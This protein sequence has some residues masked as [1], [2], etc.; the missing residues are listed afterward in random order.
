MRALSVNLLLREFGKRLEIPLRR[1]SLH[2]R[3]CG[4]RCF[5]WPLNSSCAYLGWCRSTRCQCPFA[6]P[7]KASS[8]HASHGRNDM[9]MAAPDFH[10]TG[11]VQRNLTGQLKDSFDPCAAPVSTL[12]RLE[13]IT[14]MLRLPMCHSRC[15]Q[16]TIHAGSVH[17]AKRDQSECLRPVSLRIL[18]TLRHRLSSS[19]KSLWLLMMKQRKKVL[20]TVTLSRMPSKQDCSL[21]NNHIK[22][23]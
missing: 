2:A 4:P 23:K 11:G 5:G 12:A 9:I 1:I 15:Q 22:Q 21:N 16:S 17:A 6:G 7:R 14:Q 3:P 8:S 20:K 18:P 13:K 19:R 10:T